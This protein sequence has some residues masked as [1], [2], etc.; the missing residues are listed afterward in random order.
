M[1][2]ANVENTIV[3]EVMASDADTGTGDIIYTKNVV[4]IG[5]GQDSVEE[6][7]LVLGF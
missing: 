5:H 6:I 2:Y 4:R 7:K 3:C 1:D